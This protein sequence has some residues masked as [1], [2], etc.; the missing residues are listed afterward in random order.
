MLP[1]RQHAE[2]DIVLGA[3]TQLCP[4]GSQLSPYV[5]PINNDGTRAWWIQ[6]SQQGS[7][8]RKGKKKKCSAR[9]RTIRSSLIYPEAGSSI[10]R[11]TS[12]QLSIVIE[13][14]QMFWGWFSWFLLLVGF[15]GWLVCWWVSWFIF[16]IW[17]QAFLISFLPEQ[18]FFYPT[19]STGDC[20]LLHMGILWGV[21]PNGVPSCITGLMKAD[22]S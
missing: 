22:Y 2:Q 7:D 19:Q 5:L 6:T 15:F 14:P 17:S 9:W 21:C 10:L 16:W 20:F 11:A 12:I 8:R 18:F 4:D 3:N 1:H 13:T